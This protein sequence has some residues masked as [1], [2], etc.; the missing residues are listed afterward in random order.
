M[1]LNVWQ[2]HKKNVCVPQGNYASDVS[3][4][5]CHPIS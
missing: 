3:Q 2:T 4:V 5:L 1:F